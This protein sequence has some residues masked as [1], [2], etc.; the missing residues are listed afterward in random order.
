MFIKLHDGLMQEE[1][2]M[3]SISLEFNVNYREG[4]EFVIIL[5]PKITL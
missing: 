3:D 2:E 1:E 5:L 4:I